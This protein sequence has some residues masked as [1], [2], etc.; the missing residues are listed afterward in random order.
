MISEQTT[1]PLGGDPRAE[2]AFVAPVLATPTRAIRGMVREEGSIE[3]QR[4]AV[5]V[6]KKRAWIQAR[7]LTIIATEGPKTDGELEDRAEFKF[8]GKTTVRK[9]RSE[10]Y[11]ANPPLLVK[12]GRRDGMAVWDLATKGGATGG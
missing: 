1:F 12:V 3:T 4:A 9:R 8:L 5:D 11:H 2:A 10:L 6:L 7:I